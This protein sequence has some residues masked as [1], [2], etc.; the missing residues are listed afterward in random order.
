[1]KREK[2]LEI[3]ATKPD[4]IIDFPE[5]MFSLEKVMNIHPRGSAVIGEIAGRDSIVAILKAQE[6]RQFSFLLPSIVYTGTEYGDPEILIKRLDFVKKELAKRDAHTFEPVIHGSPKLWMQLCANSVEISI[7]RWGFYT[8]CIA[9][10]LYLHIMRALLAIKLKISR[11]VTGER[12]SHEGVIK[13][14]QLPYVLESF[15]DFFASYGIEL[16]QPLKNIASN[17]EIAKIA[18]SEEGKNLEQLGCVMSGNYKD[19]SKIREL[20]IEEYLHAELLPKAKEI[21]DKILTSG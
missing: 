19:L 13:L 2:L 6:L 16:M 11:I 5:W 10:H 4:I 14:N 21:I 3:F 1:M 17:E 8:P 20:P 18:G 9:C 15:K 12:S 7:E